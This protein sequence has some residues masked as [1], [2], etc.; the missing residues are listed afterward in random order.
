MNRSIV[1][2]LEV[3]MAAPCQVWEYNCIAWRVVSSWSHRLNNAQSPVKTLPRQEIFEGLFLLTLLLLPICCRLFTQVFYTLLKWHRKINYWSLFSC[4]PLVFFFHL[5][6]ITC[7]CAAEH[8]ALFTVWPVSIWFMSC[9]AQMYASSIKSCLMC[10][11]LEVAQVVPVWA[12][13]YLRCSKRRVNR[14]CL[15]YIETAG[16]IWIARSPLRDTGGRSCYMCP[17]V[18]IVIIFYVIFCAWW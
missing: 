17:W 6:A 8:G 12:C 3:Y 14:L 15:G 18:T 13:P 9:Q 4:I 2:W 5:S 11:S 1:T 10:I 16:F 7:Y